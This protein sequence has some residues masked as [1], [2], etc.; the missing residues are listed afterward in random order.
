MK[1]HLI[2]FLCLFPAFQLNAQDATGTSA[3]VTKHQ[4]SKKAKREVSNNKIHF[5]TASFYANKFEGRKT[6][7]GEIFSQKKLTGASNI[8][9]LNQWV[10]VTN[11]RNNL[12][13]VL[14]ITDRMHKNNRRLIDLSKSAAKKLK[15]T[16][17]G[18]AHVKVEVL[19][20]KLPQDIQRG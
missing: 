19:G 9:P 8:L 5:G 3:P 11:M 6:A 18:L 13:V 4:K 2:L 17:Y 10:R 20:K 12:S 15:Y 14:R 16:G 1:K 7:N